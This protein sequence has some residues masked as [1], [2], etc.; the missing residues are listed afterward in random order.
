[1][2]T[3][4]HDTDVI[5]SREEGTSLGLGGYLNSRRPVSLVRDRLREGRTE[6]ES[7][8][9]V[10]G[11]IETELAVNLMEISRI[12]FG[13]VSLGILGLCPSVRR[14]V[15]AGEVAAEGYGATSLLRAL[16]SGSRSE[17]GFPVGEA[18]HRG[19]RSRGVAS[20]GP[21]GR[22]EIPSCT[23]DESFVHVPFG[24]GHKGIAW[25]YAPGPDLMLTAASSRVIV[26]YDIE[27]EEPPPLP[28]LFIIP[29]HLIS[30]LEHRPF[31][32]F[33][34]ASYPLYGPCVPAT[35]TYLEEYYSIDG[36]NH[37]T[38]VNSLAA[39]TDRE[40]VAQYSSR[41]ELDQIIGVGLHTHPSAE[42]YAERL[43]EWI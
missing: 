39:L 22:R 26:S 27:V 32:A 21:S 24:N 16:Q 40:F 1:M 34:A 12:V 15:E 23:P 37:E 19:L 7:L 8:V 11:G 42:E 33:P 28:N 31:G 17:A 2:D 43:I 18:L 35:V 4:L 29:T 20:V 14:R 9:V 6:Y 13:V 36:G 3:E 41:K 30:S 38:F 25:G 10:F 5:P